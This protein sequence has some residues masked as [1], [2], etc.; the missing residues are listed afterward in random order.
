MSERQKHILISLSISIG[1]LVANF[2]HIISQWFN[3]PHDRLY[4]WIAHYYADYFLYVSQIAQGIRGNW[5]ISS[6]M[7]TNEPIPDTWVYWPNVLIGK[8]GSGV[9]TSPFILYTLSLVLFV[10]VLLFLLYTLT[11]LIF[12]KQPHI[13]RIAF[14]FCTT[15]S[16]FIHI[17]ALLS[18]GEFSLTHQMWFSPTPALNRFGGVPHQTL[19]TILLLCVILLSARLFIFP[20]RLKQGVPIYLLFII[21][22]FFAATVSPIQMLLVSSAIV[23]TL[24]VFKPNLQSIIPVTLGLLAAATGAYMVNNAFDQ[25]PLYTVAKAWEAAQGVTASGIGLLLAMGPISVLLPFGVYAFLKKLSPLRLILFSYGLIS[26][27]AFVSPIPHILTTSP[28]R[29]I[30]PAS[31]VIWYCIAALGTIELSTL[32]S[33]VYTSID[34]K[35]IRISHICS[36]MLIVTY[37]LITL[38]AIITQVRARSTKEAASI[39]YSDVNHVPLPIISALST[40]EI[41][42]NTGVVLTDPTLPYD[43]LVP[44]FT[45]KRS[46]TGHPVHTL[47]PQ[48]KEQLRQQ[49]FSGT[50]N[51]QTAKQF[52]TDHS[53][54]YVIASAPAARILPSYSFLTSSYYNEAITIYETKK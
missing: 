53:I 13:Q 45:G 15:A 49:F 39:L 52:L 4:I 40:L 7:Y 25:S 29:W 46:F 44:I 23:F 48:V 43:A 51:E 32:F 16:N 17:P 24:V 3:N 1:V 21:M 2:W 54:H 26:F 42:P 37:I 6:S 12:P 47:F 14:L 33:R 9:T 50:M 35:R 36:S 18:R 22:C 10:S 19:Q 5:I 30:H 8:I 31:F 20:Q 27:A 28:T 11:R 41:L 34:T 38:P